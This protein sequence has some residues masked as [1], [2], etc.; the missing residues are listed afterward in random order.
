M[1]KI[2]I[3]CSCCGL[4]YEMPEDCQLLECP[5]CGTGNARPR[6]TGNALQQLQRAVEQ[7]LACDF[8]AA[9][10]SYQ[11]VLL[12]NPDEHEA[13][14][15]RL[16]C[17][18]G[19]EYVEDPAT[20]RRMP[21]VH[22]ARTKP[23]QAQ[24]DFRHACEF[25]P[26]AIRAQYEQ[27]ARYIDEA[28]NR[29]RE[30]AKTLPPYDVFL[31]HK[32]TKPGSKEY[33]QDFHRATQLYHLLKDQGVKVFFAPECLQNVAGANYEAG[34]YHAIHTA[35]TMLVV[36]SDKDYL[37]SA[38]VRSEWSRFLELMDER[39]ELRLIPLM[40]DHFSAADL[41][42]PFRFRGL[43]GM[44]MTDITAAQKLLE[45]LAPPAPKEEP[46][47]QT[48]TD[49]PAAKPFNIPNLTDINFDSAKEA[50]GN[51][52]NQVGEKIKTAAEK[53]PTVEKAPKPKTPAAPATQ[54]VPDGFVNVTFP[55]ALP[56]WQ[57]MQSAKVIWFKYKLFK[58]GVKE[59]LSEIKW[60][61]TVQVAAKD[62]DV[63]LISTFRSGFFRKLLAALL[64]LLCLLGLVVF[65]G[66]T[67]TGSF[68]EGWEP[69]IPLTLSAV[70]LVLWA[71]VIPKT[72][73]KI[74]VTPC[75]RYEIMWNWLK[76][77]LIYKQN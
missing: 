12:E 41:P 6:S 54:Y 45:L 75:K 58:K 1:E 66:I 14:W 67:S 39:A 60:G 68:Y 2:I 18:Y 55:A 73:L 51:V 38:W 50:I 33:T 47:K 8:A 63:L 48:A 27:E 35:K 13:L 77:K 59:P 4:S 31:C 43:Q 53:V 56:A 17:H 72:A 62:G 64:L 40:Y 30:I 25:A 52:V 21:T 71:L 61:E 19:V 46:K 76:T 57:K 70:M 44:D 15:G 49:K 23:L 29:I 28:Q 37:T 34:I 24:A 65:I 5:A 74:P 11:H 22:T 42:M 26:E 36:C 10:T 16:L 20:G 69:L 32:T 3:T 7:R 9:E